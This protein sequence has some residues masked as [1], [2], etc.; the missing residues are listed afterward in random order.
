[1]K[2][3]RRF[4]VR[5][6]AS[7][8]RHPDEKR[9][10]EE[11]KEHLAMQTAENIG[12]GM[13]P[14]EARRQAVLKFGAVEAIKEGYRDQRTLPAL[15]NLIQDIRYALRGLRKNPGFTA[16]A[17]ITL[18]LGI[19]ATTAIFTVVNA[20]L[21]R[22]LP[23]TEPDRLVMIRTEGIG[24]AAE[25][26]LNGAEIQ[27]IRAA[28]HVFDQVAAIVAVVGSVTGESEMERVT[29]ANVT[30]NFLPMLGVVPL[31]GRPLDEQIDV[32]TEAI[33]SVVISHEL[34]QR[35]YGGDPDIIGRPTE[36]NNIPVTVVGVMPRSFKLL[37]RKDTDVA[38]LIDIW[39]TTGLERFDRQARSRTVIARLARG[40]TLDRARNEM[41]ALSA[42][43]TADHKDVYARAPLQLHVEPLQDDTVSDVRATLLALMGSV[44]LVL[45]IACAN[46]ANL[47][48]AR[49]TGRMNE[50]AV[51]SAIGADRGRL[52]R[53]LMTESLI[54]GMIGGLAGVFVAQWT[55]SL[56]LWLRPSGLPPVNV[57]VDGSTLMFAV[58]ITVATILMYSVIPAL[59]AARI[60][61]A[62]ALNRGRAGRSP[63][64]RISSALVI[65]EIALS[66]V[67]LVGAGLMI[68]TIVALQA[69]RTGFNADGVLTMQAQIRTRDFTQDAVRGRWQ[70]YRAAVEQLSALPGVQSV[71]AVRPLPLESTVFTD[72][73]ARV[74]TSDELIATWHTTLP[75]FFR[76]MGIRLLEGREF[77]PMDMDQRRPV[78]IV[79]E[80]FARTAWPGAR[81]VGQRLWRVAPKAAP[82]EVIG[83]VDH[84]HAQS[85][86]NEGGPQV[87]FPYHRH[88]LGDLAIVMRVSG[89]P[90][91]LANEARSTFESLGGRRPAYDVRPLT[92]YVEDATH[93]ARFIVALLS[94]FAGLA[95]VLAAIGI[96]GVINEVVVQ[97]TRE[98]GVRIALGSGRGEV[99][100]LVLARA[101]V[102]TAGGLMLG[103]VGAAAATRYLQ[104]ML[105]GLTALDPPT[106]AVVILVFGAV[107]LLA[108]YVPARR[109]ARVDPLVALRYE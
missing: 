108:S 20:V 96:Y 21:L 94:I 38:A 95:L 83:V 52:F 40:V 69:V 47:V 42:R 29:T 9:L 33:L 23:Y 78:A 67:L 36:V 80:R 68:R 53:Q 109:A 87:Y 6:A 89:D 18:A 15:D 97:S 76:T 105:F 64:R 90:M 31:L 25:P 107:A 77:E 66:V 48:I 79:D 104:A 61:V 81:A 103:I 91:L 93:E 85:L 100:R 7:I 45:L 86:R 12:A 28:T 24:G 32:S 27:D 62:H 82:M 92:A 57:A 11:V 71:S 43:V 26:L 13:S 51:R 65:G 22:P 84:V 14:E 73:F 60:N 54:L 74:G 44:A 55:G 3:L 2:G 50:F 70:F 101:G 5:L 8:T 49:L 17:I 39:L 88:A 37:L 102:L 41:A 4:L 19:G 30:D 1:M 72:R 99:L 98:I 75:G 63:S 16:V 106:Y 59:C 10:T 46:V 35:R 56:L 34:W 58:G